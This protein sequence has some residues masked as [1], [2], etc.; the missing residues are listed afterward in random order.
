[1]ITKYYLYNVSYVAPQD[2]SFGSWELVH[3]NSKEHS[4]EYLYPGSTVKIGDK[5]YVDLSCCVTYKHRETVELHKF[6]DI[7]SDWNP[8]KGLYFIALRKQALA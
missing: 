2:L 4:A 8:T 1:M 3:I 6:F 5:L 7:G